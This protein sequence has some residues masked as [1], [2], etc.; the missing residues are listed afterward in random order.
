MISIRLGKHQHRRPRPPTAWVLIVWACLAL[1]VVTAYLPMAWDRYQ[2]PIQAPAALLAA[3]ALASAW[4]ALRTWI[5]R[6][7]RRR[8]TRTPWLRVE[9]WVFV[10]LMTSYAFFWHSRDWN[11]ASRLM[12]TYA[13][14]DRGTVCLDGL[15]RQTGDIA[16]LQ[17]Q[18]Y[19]DKLPGFSLLAAIPYASRPGGLRPSRSSLGSEA[20]AY[21]PADYWVTLGTSGLFTA[22]T[23]VLL[24]E[25]ARDLGCSPR[26]A[27]LVGLA[28]GLATPAYVYATLAYGHQVSAFA[29]ARVVLPALEAGAGRDAARLVA[30]GFLAAYAAVVELQ[31][32]PVSAIL[33]LY[34]WFNAFE[35]PPARRPGLLRV[36]AAVPNLALARLQPAGVRLALGHGLLSPR[37]GHLRQGP[38]S[39]EPSRPEAAGPELAGSPA[40]GRVSR[41]ALLCAH[42]AAGDPGMVGACGAQAGSTWLSCRWRSPRRSCS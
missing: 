39:Q 23:A 20:K 15:D 8:M 21:W 33:G 29:L 1:G 18:Y 26:R 22:L 19:C 38:Q 12:L 13:M 7:A 42:P 35:A 27:A 28:Y 14:V 25:I 31:V 17:G 37:N 3:L 10:I 24:V 5:T 34:L 41:A 36:G 4:E 2:L 16:K 9:C 6:P 11:T 32:G 30:A 40:L